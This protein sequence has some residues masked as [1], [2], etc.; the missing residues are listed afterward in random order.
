[1]LLPTV[2]L[3]QPPPPAAA[4]PSRML[5]SPLPCSIAGWCR[6]GV[7]TAGAAAFEAGGAWQQA[8]GERQREVQPSAWGCEQQQR[9]QQQQQSAA[10]AAEPLAGG[11]AAAGRMRIEEVASTTKTQRVSTHSHVKGLGLQVGTHR[12]CCCARFTLQRLCVRPAV[13]LMQLRVNG[14]DLGGRL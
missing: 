10:A 2:P 9:Q 7:P 8:C 11:A 5:F 4:T 6:A 13:R 12:L 3:L 14:L 1:M